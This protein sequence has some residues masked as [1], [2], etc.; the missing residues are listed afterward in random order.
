MA[1]NTQDFRVKNGI[2]VNN[3]ATIG[4]TVSIS[5]NVTI[6]GKSLIIDNPTG[7]SINATGRS[8]L[9]NSVTISKGNLTVSNGA[10]S[11]TSANATQST[12]F[13]VNTETV[14]VSGN[15]TVTGIATF[16]S[17]Q[18]L[19]IGTGDILLYSALTGAPAGNASITVNRGTSPDVYILWDETTSTWK[20]TNDGTYFFPIRTYSDLVYSFDT[21]TAMGTAP[22]SGRMRLNNAN[23]SL[24]TIVSFSSSEFGGNS[25]SDIW[26]AVG[27]SSSANKA[28][29]YIRSS[30]NTNEF[31][32]YRITS[33]ADTSVAN[34]I[35]FNITY[36]GGITSGFTSLENLT[37]Q[38]SLSGDKGDIGSK[39]DKG[40]IG[41]TGAKGDKGDTGTAGSKGDKGEV[42]SKGDKGDKGDTGSTGGKGDKGDTGSTGRDAGIPYT[43]SVSTTESASQP[44]IGGAI[45]NSATLGSVT[46][47]TVR[48]VDSNNN[49]SNNLFNAF[50]SYGNTTLKGL[51]TVRNVA[52]TSQ[53]ALFN[54]SSVSEGSQATNKLFTVSNINNGYTAVF[55]DT[56]SLLFTFTPNGLGSKGDT[57]TTGTTGS[58]GDKGDQGAKGDKGDLG[59]TGT[60]GDKGDQGAK[61]DKGDAGSKGDSGTSGLTAGINYLFDTGTTE[62]VSAPGIGSLIFNSATPSS[63]T[64]ITVRNIDNTGA[65]NQ[66]LISN[67]NNLGNTTF[68]G[69]LEITN[70]ANT[71]QTL[72]YSVSN[73]AAGSQ[74][75]NS[76][77][78]VTNITGSYNS[79][80]LTGANLAVQFTG[81]G[82]S[83]KGD[84]GTT[85]AK[86]DKGDAF[87]TLTAYSET[88]NT[89]TVS[90]STYNIDLSLSNIFNLTLA[91]SVTFTFTNPPT[92]GFTKPVTVI[93]K[94]DGTGSRTAS[95]TGAKYTDAVS[96]VLT[97]TANRSDV[98]TFFTLDGGTSYFGTFAMANVA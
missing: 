50:G 84:T 57:G 43:F 97:T 41:V 53:T 7:L 17:A 59:S 25:T 46:S 71:S 82:L 66:L 95:F 1:A 74:A 56:S 44:P 6:N 54:V 37:V 30:E 16:Q 49:D 98:L 18:R 3:T 67:Y 70:I 94:Q 22:V 8:V 12:V 65:N 61:G 91:T 60:K 73:T 52:N 68:K 23:Y 92:V 36:L 40:D 47:I 83:I 86:G 13:T 2:V 85:G 62:S 9:G 58:K 76:K 29:L 34:A 78:N 4:N 26:N 24:A 77:F 10:F 96:P 55:Q 27:S 48:K 69:Y 32:V 79:P 45:F 93:L 63:V 15:L 88:V 75:Y 33:A 38:V 39:G 21:S 14:T 80:F 11:V 5:G 81:T 19:E 42:G 64:A 35:K 31:A 87:T 90:T 72:L 28:L 20:F 51:L 89:A